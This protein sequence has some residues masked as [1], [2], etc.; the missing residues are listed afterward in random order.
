MP[1][2]LQI[3]NVY[4]SRLIGQMMQDE[5]ITVIPTIQYAGRETYEFCFDG[6]EPGGVIATSTV[7][8]SGSMDVWRE[9]MDEAI[10]RL[11][12]SCVV[13][14]GTANCYDFGGVRVKQIQVPH[15]RWGKA[16]ERYEIAHGE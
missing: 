15:R 11:N 8:C 5:G 1:L 3:Y 14:Y 16:K 2:A 13:C 6:I 12:P 4:R 7:G 10:R 9:G